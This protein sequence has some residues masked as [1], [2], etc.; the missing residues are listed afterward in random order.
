MAYRVN[1]PIS[2]GNG[3]MIPAGTIVDASQWRNLRALVNG[4]FLVEVLDATVSED[5][6]RTAVKSAKRVKLT[7]E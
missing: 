1:K 5:E 3:T 4:R 7:K 6:S 2:S